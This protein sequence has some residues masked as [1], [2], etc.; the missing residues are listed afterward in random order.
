MSLI[1]EF[2]AFLHLHRVS[3]I[4]EW[5]LIWTVLHEQ[6]SAG[7]SKSWE[8]LL[9][10]VSYNVCSINLC[11]PKLR[12]NSREWQKSWA[13]AP[14]VTGLPWPAW[15]LPPT[16]SG[17][18]LP[19][20]L[21]SHPVLQ[22]SFPDTV[23]GTA[24]FFNSKQQHTEHRSTSLEMQIQG[25]CA[26]FATKQRH[27]AYSQLG[28]PPAQDIQRILDPVLMPPLRA[29][30]ILTRTSASSKPAHKDGSYTTCSSITSFRALHTWGAKIDWK[31][32]PQGL[33]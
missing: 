24:L 29:E 10:A 9:S 32:F 8:L 33:Q 1:K 13:R 19:K 21:G 28:K 5:I 16:V 25:E 7:S 11:N 22:D 23:L 30:Q 31:A 4:H 6:I 12:H 15:W 18:L 14:S 20:C 2:E 26:E 3:A 17:L 27:L